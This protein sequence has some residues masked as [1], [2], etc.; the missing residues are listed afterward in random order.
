MNRLPTT[1]SADRRIR[2]ILGFLFV[3]SLVFGLVVAPL[4]IITVGTA[5]GQPTDQQESERPDYEALS[6]ELV[7]AA[8]VDFQTEPEVSEEQQAAAEM[9]V[10]EGIELARTEG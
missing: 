8:E 7:T 1:K 9:G 5:V 3:F 4:G 6:N 2:Q 10:Q